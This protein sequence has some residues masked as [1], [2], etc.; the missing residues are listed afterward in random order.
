[1]MELQASAGNS[2]VVTLLAGDASAPGP[3]AQVQRST[4]E[5]E[6]AG[7]LHSSLFHGNDYME[8]VADGQATLA[9]GVSAAAPVRRLQAGLILAVPDAYL[10][11]SGLSGVD[12]DFG[13][14]TEGAVK[15]FQAECGLKVDGV[16]GPATIRQLDSVVSAHPGTGPVVDPKP[17]EDPGSRLHD[18][19]AGELPE[20]SPPMGT[21][22]DLSGFG[23]R[24]VEVDKTTAR[25]GRATLE[26]DETERPNVHLRGSA[27]ANLEIGYALVHRPASRSMAAKKGK[28]KGKKKGTEVY[29][30]DVKYLKVI[31]DIEIDSR[32]PTIEN[33]GCSL[34]E[35]EDFLENRDSLVRTGESN[36]DLMKTLPWTTKEATRFHEYMHAVSFHN[37]MRFRL[38]P[39]YRKAVS[40]IAVWA[41]DESEKPVE[42]TLTAFKEATKQ[43]IQLPWRG[44]EKDDRTAWTPHWDIR[45]GQFFLLVS[46]YDNWLKERKG[47]PCP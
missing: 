19:P 23:V 27:G 11:T 35:N 9:K 6:G 34:S 10:G 8:S 37:T 29:G 38:E 18:D 20:S 46:L 43:G 7:S 2:A 28:K 30:V 13:P 40:S 12:G 3:G 4:A 26:I 41:D 14:L 22:D 44:L 31:A 47:V 25:A 45:E 36:L 39:K 24:V 5:E 21:I 33:F 42:K 15:A 1:M 32:L 17:K 16:V